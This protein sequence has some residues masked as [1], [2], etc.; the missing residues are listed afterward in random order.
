MQDDE[1]LEANSE[2]NRT[3]SRVDSGEYL[4]N[5]IRSQTQEDLNLQNI[6]QRKGHLILVLV[7]LLIINLCLLLVN[8]EKIVNSMCKKK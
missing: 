1:Y 8:L 7:Y 2:Y 4:H 5:V 6:N 3:Q